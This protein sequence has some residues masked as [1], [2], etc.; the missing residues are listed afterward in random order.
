M[1]PHRRV[2]GPPFLSTK[3]YTAIACQW[4]TKAL[5]RNNTRSTLSRT[6]YE[7]FSSSPTFSDTDLE[8]A[9]NIA[10]RGSPQLFL[11][12]SVTSFIDSLHTHT[13]RTCIHTPT[14]CLT[15]SP[16]ERMN[17]L[18]E[19]LA[20]IDVLGAVAGSAQSA[21][22]ARLHCAIFGNSKICRLRKSRKCAQ[23]TRKSFDENRLHQ[24]FGPDFQDNN[25]HL[26]R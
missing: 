3:Q 22:C 10:S 14:S 5:P 13:A 7:I 1:I 11:A 20:L 8:Q 16:R 21:D 12:L 18:W 25:W 9:I 6:T 19:C 23:Q 4:G 26:Y 24:F 2:Q 15:I 17:I